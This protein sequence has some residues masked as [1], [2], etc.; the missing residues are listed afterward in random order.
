ML[1]IWNDVF[2]DQDHIDLAA[3]IKAYNK[4]SDYI[5]Y[6]QWRK[7]IKKIKKIYEQK[8]I[9]VLNTYSDQKVIEIINTLNIENN[10]EFNDE[11]EIIL[12]N[13]Y[14]SFPRF[15]HWFIKREFERFFDEFDNHG[16][17]IYTI[18]WEPIN[19]SWRW[20]SIIKYTLWINGREKMIPAQLA[21]ILWLTKS[22]ICQIQQKNIN[23]LIAPY[24]I[25]ILDNQQ[26]EDFINKIIE[27][28]ELLG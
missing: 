17:L 7:I 13:T 19:M 5:L 16:E 26:R 14:K 28:N 6:N 8:I 21:F 3:L 23:K 18:E 9:D 12:F 1:N 27:E 15:N 4:N 25:E 2:F 22:R 20:K 24:K 11:K 10:I